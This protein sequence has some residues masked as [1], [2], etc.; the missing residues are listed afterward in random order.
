[1]N[2]STFGPKMEA[3]IKHIQRTIGL[4]ANGVVTPD[5]ERALSAAFVASQSPRPN[6]LLQSGNAGRAVRELQA[7]LKA[8]GHSV[9]VDG[10]FGPTTAR[11]VRAFQATHGLD[12]DGVA[13]PQTT[14][15]LDILEAAKDAVSPTERAAPAA[16]VSTPRSSRLMGR[17]R[18]VRL[19]G[20]PI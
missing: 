9:T 20:L 1:M 7:Q 16:A 13:G 6:G 3:S 2:S 8:L 12:A 18:S 15:L 4:E 17:S 19:W 14:R 10:D 11:V 5:T